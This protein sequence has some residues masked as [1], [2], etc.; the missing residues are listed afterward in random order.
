VFDV[1]DQQVCWLFASPKDQA[2]ASGMSEIDNPR[3]NRRL[4]RSCVSAL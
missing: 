4:V 2:L 3:G 1:M